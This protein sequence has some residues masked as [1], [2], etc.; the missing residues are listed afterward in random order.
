MKF[1]QFRNLDRTFAPHT[2]DKDL[3]SVNNVEKIMAHKP[4]V[5]IRLLCILLIPAKT[6][7]LEGKPKAEMLERQSIK[8]G[9]IVYGPRYSKDAPLSMELLVDN[10]HQTYLVMSTEDNKLV[11]KQNPSGGR[12]ETTDG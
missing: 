4:L 12:G 3:I 7:I 6:P 9:A 10:K 5:S 2:T 8:L 11:A 1:G